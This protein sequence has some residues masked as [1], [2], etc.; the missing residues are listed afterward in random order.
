[1][2]NKFNKNVI[3]KKSEY[4]L[5]NQFILESALNRIDKKNYDVKILEDN[6]TYK[7]IVS[8]KLESI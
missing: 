3:I 2:F 1:M 4:N 8:R 7:L 6:K 5:A